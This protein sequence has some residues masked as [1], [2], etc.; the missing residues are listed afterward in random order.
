MHWRI[1]HFVVISALV[2]AALFA[3]YT[4]LPMQ[5]LALPAT[6]SSAPGFSIVLQQANEQKAQ[7]QQKTPL[8]QRKLLARKQARHRSASK[9]D[10]KVPVATTQTQHAVASPVSAQIQQLQIRD[11][12]LSRI[13]SHL[14]QYFFYPLLAQREG[15]QGRVLLG[16]SVEAN[17]AIRNIHVAVGSGYSILDHSAVSALSRLDTISEAGNWLRGKRLV[18]QM[19]VVFRLQGG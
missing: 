13:R 1:H 6:P 5:R 3:V 14:D 15:W 11:R 7:S 9:A 10:H 2:H 12:V 16:F 19:P 18:L 8:A 17:G 4:S